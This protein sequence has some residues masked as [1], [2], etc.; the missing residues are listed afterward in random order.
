M[1][2]KI[3]L[4]FILMIISCRPAEK[5]TPFGKWKYEKLERVD[6]YAVDLEIPGKREIHERNQGLVMYFS[7]TAYQIKSFKDSTNGELLSAGEYILSEDRNIIRLKNNNGT[8]V[9]F[10]VCELSATQFKINGSSTN[11]DCLVFRKIN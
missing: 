11:E 4:L 9:D 8:A 2:S 10:M 6:G 1:S 5:P 3:Y 7:A